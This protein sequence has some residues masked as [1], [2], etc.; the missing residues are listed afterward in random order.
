MTGTALVA[1]IVAALW[2]A[3]VAVLTIGD[4]KPAPQHDD[5]PARDCRICNAAWVRATITG[6]DCDNHA[7]DIAIVEHAARRRS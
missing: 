7:H 6:N 1:A 3:A 4:S 5:G 2:L